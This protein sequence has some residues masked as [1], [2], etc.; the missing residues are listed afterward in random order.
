MWLRSG[1]IRGAAFILSLQFPLSPILKKERK[2]GVQIA[3]AL[4][5]VLPVLMSQQGHHKEESD[6]TKTGQCSRQRVSALNQSWIVSGKSL[7][8]KP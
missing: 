1:L 7:P 4:S 2:S 5:V 3:R 6:Y 8:F